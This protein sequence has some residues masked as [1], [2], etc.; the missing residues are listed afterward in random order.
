M[1]SFARVAVL[2]PVSQTFHYRVPEHLRPL[3]EP[4]VR[5]SV[6]F[7]KTRTVGFILALDPEADVPRVRDLLEILD[8]EPCL[9]PDL[10]E[11]GVWLAAYY[12]HPP[13]ET[14][15]ALLPPSARAWAEPVYEAV[16]LPADGACPAPPADPG[17]ALLLARIRARGELPTAQLRASEQGS[18]DVLLRS[19]AVERR[20]RVSAPS[21]QRG[22]EWFSLSPGGPRPEEVERRAPRQADVLRALG[23]GPVPA[24]VLRAQGISR[25]ALLR[26]RERGWVTSRDAPP[27]GADLGRF[28]LGGEGAVLRLT[29]EQRR[30]VELVTARL[31]AG[32]FS[33][34]LLQGVTGSGKTE[35]YIR[36]VDAARRAGKGAVVLVPEIGLTPQMLGR[37]AAAFGAG[38]GLLHS[39]LGERERRLQWE[40]L[41][42]GDARI[43][44]GARS[45]VFAPVRDLGLIVVDEE[46]ESAYKQ[47]DGLRYHAKHA[48][49]MRARACGAVVLL[50]SATPDV[51]TFAAADSGRYRRVVLPS[52]VGTAPAPE[53]RVVDLRQEESR[54]R[55]RVLFSDPLR[56]A[57]ARALARGEQA[58][59]FLNRRGFSPAVVCSAC[60]AAVT[61]SHCSIAL[62]L[63][64]GPGNPNLMCHYCGSRR[65][66]P[67]R[68]P[69]CGAEG[70]A[71]AGAGTQ[72]LVEEAG[73][74]W[75]G[76]RVLRLDRDTTRR[77]GG[78]EVLGA[79]GRG[80][81][82]LLVGTQMV[83]K[84]HHFPR[85]T[86]VGVV[87]ADLSL[88]FPDFRAAERTFQVLTQVAG[89]AGREDLPGQV[90]L[91]TRDPHHPTL[92]AAVAGDYEAFA[93]AEL[94]IRQEAGFPPF[95]RLALLRVSGPRAEEARS[96]AER[97][98]EQ[99]RRRGGG[100]VEVLGPAPAPLERLRGRWRFQI[101]LRAPGAEP[102]PLQGLLRRLLRDNLGELS[103]D[104]RL[105]V[106]VDPVSLL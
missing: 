26:A 81:A 84:G 85:L 4:G 22:E 61:C 40:R 12:H 104:L 19:G 90:F 73:A 106:D 91:Q 2:R 76:A 48:A 50:G 30:A 77:C 36:A 47:E 35:V 69:G 29:D 49:L 32:A 20:W 64:R 17:A 21:P 18:L 11:L 89:R 68:C 31:A 105:H 16:A 56:E 55:S 71:A 24:A 60:A 62:T 43:A 100:R 95:R 38:I 9:T 92:A 1:G 79:F 80:E 87:D 39:G 65:P 75:E 66:V 86:V 23:S 101:L 54:R 74:V 13:G 70:L 78:A 5:C 102:G 59:L 98:A 63:H 25:E 57:V 6:P 28:G 3:A 83:A 41:L 42:R 53:I 93:R 72:R 8:P 45:A 46:H 7:G 52:R 34:I 94:A 33:P 15:A 14:L 88:H 96:R 37:F 27:E 44:L 99:A 10:L 67:T 58:L 82:D 103:G 51:E 97:V